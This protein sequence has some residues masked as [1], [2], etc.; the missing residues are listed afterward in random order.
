M[1]WKTSAA[2][3]SPPKRWSLGSAASAARPAPSA[4]ATRARRLGDFL[5]PPRDTGAP[6]VLLRQ[7]VGRHLRPRLRHFDAALLEDDGAVG[8]RISESPARNAIPSNGDF[9]LA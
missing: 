7:H 4:T 8:L 3:R 9:L 1:R 6:E 5:Q 2:V